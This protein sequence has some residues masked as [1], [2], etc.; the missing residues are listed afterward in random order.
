M[1]A[2]ACGG[3]DVVP[4]SIQLGFEAGCAERSCED[5]GMACGASVGIRIVDAESLAG[6]DAGAGESPIIFEQCVQIEPGA[7][8]TLC[9]LDDIELTFPDVPA[10]RVQIQVALWRPETLD[11]PSHCPTDIFDYRGEPLR[12]DPQPAFGGANYFDVGGDAVAQVTLWCSDPAQLDA[13][14]CLPATQ[15]VNATL[16]DIV[17]GVVVTTEEAANFDV[18]V[19]EPRQPSEEEWV[20]EP[21]DTYALDLVA[22][23]T[24]SWTAAGLPNFSAT[25]CVLALDKLVAESVTAVTCTDDL[26]P[27][28]H[29]PL[30][31]AAS[32]LDKGVLTQI[33]TAAELAGFPAEGLVVG[34]VVNDVG[35]PLA[36]VVVSGTS[37]T[38]QYLSADRLSVDGTETSTDAFF[39][40]RDA[41]YNTR[42]TAIQPIDGREEDGEFRAGLIA[43]KVSLVTIKMDKLIAPTKR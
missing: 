31:L 15:V 16:D 39:I 7:D 33:L 24:P 10:R 19:G 32:V 5:Y 40:S 21:G 37:A 6:V 2:I 8:R 36:G 30:E 23:A 18:S 43:G 3:D 41:E 35:S 29:G 25:V 9:E 11:D 20:L 26:T 14:E 38:V 4:F 28:P 12:V 17:T 27:S 34:R 1:A 13:D 22:A 42:W